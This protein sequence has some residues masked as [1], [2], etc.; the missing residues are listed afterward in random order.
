MFLASTVR[1]TSFRHPVFR[2]H[3]VGW[4]VGSRESGY[5]YSNERTSRTLPAA[6]APN[7]GTIC[8]ITGYQYTSVLREYK[9]RLSIHIKDKNDPYS[10][11]QICIIPAIMYYYIHTSTYC[12]CSNTQSYSCV[13]Q[14]WCGGYIELEQCPEPLRSATS[15]GRLSVLHCKDV[16]VFSFMSKRS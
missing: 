1:A 8:Y 12:R 11:V 13:V 9:E 4:Q 16:W 10:S 3:P 5:G 6:A 14:V 7:T 15:T 2:M